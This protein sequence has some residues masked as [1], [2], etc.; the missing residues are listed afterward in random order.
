MRDMT[1]A[2]RQ[3]NWPAVML[4][5]L[6]EDKSNGNPGD[7]FAANGMA[8]DRQW[9]IGLKRKLYGMDVRLSQPVRL[10]RAEGRRAGADGACRYAAGS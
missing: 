5:G 1:Q 10:P 4:A 2:F 8:A 9:W 6:T 3:D 7:W